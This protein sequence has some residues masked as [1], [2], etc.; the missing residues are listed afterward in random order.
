M[1]IDIERQDI[2]AYRTCVR[3]VMHG[4]AVRHLFLVS[5]SVLRFNKVVSF[6]CQGGLLRFLAGCAGSC[7]PLDMLWVLGQATAFDVLETAH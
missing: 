3:P 6:P 4:D 1:V 7:R 5:S 2:A